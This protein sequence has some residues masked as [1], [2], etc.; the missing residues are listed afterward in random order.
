MFVVTFDKSVAD[1]LKMRG[2]RCVEE[3]S[4]KWVFLRQEAYAFSTEIDMSKLKGTNNLC[5]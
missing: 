5:I 2:C 3:T 4:K 1:M